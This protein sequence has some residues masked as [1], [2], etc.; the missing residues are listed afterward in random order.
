MKRTILSLVVV[1][2]LFLL[3]GCKIQFLPSSD[4][5]TEKIKT[6]EIKS[7]PIV[8][9][10][11]R[12]TEKAPKETNPEL[13]K[14]TGK[15]YAKGPEGIRP[16]NAISTKRPNKISPFS[17]G[18]T[19]FRNNRN[20]LPEVTL[21]KYTYWYECDYAGSCLDSESYVW[22][23]CYYDNFTSECEAG[24]YWLS[25]DYTV[26]CNSN[27]LCNDSNEFGW[28]DP[29]KDTESISPKEAMCCDS[30]GN[31]YTEDSVWMD[32][33]QYLN[34]EFCDECGNCY[35]YYGN[36]AGYDESSYNEELCKQYYY[37][38]LVKEWDS[39]G[40]GYD[41]NGEFLFYDNY[42]YDYQA[43]NEDY[44]SCQTSS[45]GEKNDCDTLGNCYDKNGLQ[46]EDPFYDVTAFCD[47]CG[48]CYDY[49]GN[50]TEKDESFTDDYW[51]SQYYKYENVDYYDE[52]GNAYDKNKEYLFYDNDK[53][54][55][56]A[57]YGIK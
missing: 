32:D 21:A 55:Y 47:E 51:C 31:C 56:K 28:Y 50:E 53:Y 3:T 48:N 22:Y 18:K 7:I 14:T 27:G 34:V 41:K 23:D 52:C 30:W 5:S 9:D 35:D 46:Y 10:N 38:D 26:E 13:E 43:C 12:N 11:Q 4:E 16:D 8:Y 57:C 29:L 2:S 49:Y 25:E 20:D 54:D 36:A 33:P 44:K 37:Y 17:V 45:T 24:N 40:N 39:C 42:Y 1:F 19:K 15:I 6:N